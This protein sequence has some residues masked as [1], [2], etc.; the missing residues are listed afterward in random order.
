MTK[1]NKAKPAGKAGEKTHKELKDMEIRVNEFGE[2]VK[3]YNI[4]A[5]NNFLKERVQD[6][7]LDQ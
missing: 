5:I 7:K 6:K 3:D 4:D 1:K 2:I